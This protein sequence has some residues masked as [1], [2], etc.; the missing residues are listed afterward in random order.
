M[1]PPDASGLVLE[2]GS[3]TDPDT[4]KV[5]H[6][7]EGW[8]DVEPLATRA[9][10]K[11]SCIVIQHEDKSN[12]ARGMVILL[13][14]YSQGLIRVGNDVSLERWQWTKDQG[15]KLVVKMGDQELP[16]QA[17]LAKA[18]T[19]KEGQSLE[20]ATQQWNCIESEIF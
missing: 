6:Y 9:D 4:G 16:C 1:L 19:L 14:Q 7:V 13:G 2:K 8:R 15:W 18:D 3:N 5:T 10:G 12:R 17:L 20:S 11:M